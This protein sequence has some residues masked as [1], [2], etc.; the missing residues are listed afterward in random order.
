MASHAMHP[1]Q[2]RLLEEHSHAPHHYNVPVLL[3]VQS[4]LSMRV[5]GDSL[6]A[7]AARHEALRARFPRAGGGRTQVVDPPGGAFPLEVHDLSAHPADSRRKVFD[8][9][10]GRLQLSLDIEHGPVCRAAYIRLAPGQDR[11]LLLFHHLV[12]DAL[13]CRIL[14]RELQQ[15]IAAADRGVVAGFSRAPTGLAEYAD[16]LHEHVHRP[17]SADDLDWWLA[18]PWDRVR[19][20][21]ADDPAGSLRAEDFG[22]VVS[23]LQTAD[24]RRLT[25]SAAARGATAEETLL[26]AI[27]LTLSAYSASETVAMEVLRHGRIPVRPDQSLLRTVGWTATF[28]P[29]LI[30]LPATSDPRRVLPGAVDQIRAIRERELSWGTLRYLHRDPAVR[31]AL[32]DLPAPRVRVNYRG[33]AIT[34]AH[35]ILRPP[36]TAAQEDCGQSLAPARQQSHELKI[37]ADLVDGRL[38]LVWLHSARRH[39]ESTVRGLADYLTRTLT[40]LLSAPPLTQAPARRLD[41]RRALKGTDPRCP[42]PR[43]CSTPQWNSPG[44]GATPP[45]AAPPPAA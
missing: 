34:E 8:D 23:W 14:V 31:G 30:D 9:L 25:A 35:R 37:Q 6:S 44:C 19:R 33:S 21:P 38:R 28:A 5:L 42:T 24:T 15:L 41:A 11:L 18:R 10:C 2:H 36:F 27:A 40:K 32:A 45:P 22:Q 7:S 4:G 12:V 29:H 16:A 3:A 1:M 17:G 26:T 13:S 43:A 39:S 20:L